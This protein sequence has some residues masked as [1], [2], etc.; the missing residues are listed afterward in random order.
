MPL[1]DWTM[2]NARWCESACVP[3]STGHAECLDCP[4]QAKYPA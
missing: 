3:P 1:A 2:K 4:T